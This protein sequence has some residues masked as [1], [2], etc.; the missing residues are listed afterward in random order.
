MTALDLIFRRI[1]DSTLSVWVTSL[2]VDSV[3]VMVAVAIAFEHVTQICKRI[4]EPDGQVW[5]SHRSTY[6][7]VRLTDWSVPVLLSSI[8][9]TTH[10][11]GETKNATRRI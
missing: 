3:D 10:P 8:E 9:Y 7:H 5:E 4:S 6:S 2:L 1:T 11:I